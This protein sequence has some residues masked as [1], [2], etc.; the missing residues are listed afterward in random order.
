[1]LQAADELYGALAPAGPRRAGAGAAGRECGDGP[2]HRRALAAGALRA[3][4]RLAAHRLLTNI[5]TPALNRWE[6]GTTSGA[7]SQIWA[8]Q[9]HTRTDNTAVAVSLAV[10]GIGIARIATRWAQP[11]VANGSLLKVLPGQL[12][13][14]PV[15]ICA[16]MLQ[17]RQ[18]LPRVRAVLD[19]FQRWIGPG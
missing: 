14:D 15:P 18:R 6:F 3:P 16:V 9:G 10:A 17:G 1:M 4:P 19:H 2:G 8:A 5:A 13:T 12:R 7:A 11:L